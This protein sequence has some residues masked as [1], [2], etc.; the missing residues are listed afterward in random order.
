MPKFVRRG[1]E[2]WAK[3]VAEFQRAGGTEPH[4]EFAGRHGVRVGSFQ[5]WLYR[6]RAEE[7][8][9]RRG[10]KRRI[11]GR[12]VARVPWPLVEVK[13]A[14]ATDV[15]FEIELSGGRRLRVPESFDDGV[16]RRL[17]AIFDEKPAG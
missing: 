16:L 4:A 6:L 13:T 9:R 15:R 14:R 12:Q 11:E 10:R 3:L 17:L 1:G 2:F 5:R 7:Q 8:G